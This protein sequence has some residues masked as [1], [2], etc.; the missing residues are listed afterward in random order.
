MTPEALALIHIDQLLQAAGWQ[1]RDLK[2]AN[3][4]V[5][6]GVAIR[7]Y[8]RHF[9]ELNY[10]EMHKVASCGFQPNLSLVRAVCVP[11]PPFFE[12]IRIVAE[13]D[14]HLSIIRE[15]EA[16]V[17]ANI[18]RSQALRQATLRSVFHRVVGS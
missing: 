18:L 13:V 1:V 11:L 15:V 4:H 12:Q 16:E 7:E 6:T 17:D 8:L 10:E 14:R 2:Q 9:L 3:I 5:I